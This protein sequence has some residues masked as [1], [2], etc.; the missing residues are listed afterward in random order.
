M[1]RKALK[2]LAGPFLAAHPSQADRVLPLL[3][4][5]LVDSTWHNLWTTAH[6]VACKL[7][8][9]LLLGLKQ[10]AAPTSLDAPGAT[11]ALSRTAAAALASQAT[12]SSEAATALQRLLLSR[13][14]CT[15][16]V[17][18]VA[19]AA[20]YGGCQGLALAILQQM[21]TGEWHCASGLEPVPLETTD[22]LPPAEWMERV[23]SRQADVEELRLSATLAALQAG[24]GEEL[25]RLGLQVS[26]P[27]A[28]T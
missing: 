12:K 24:P 11:A 28:H 15:A 16:A 18:L 3:L 23:G 22:G 19:C 13:Q 6:K 14:G 1:A 10:V 20:M 4:S 27:R 21:V 8:H 26:L 9:P 7:D 25:Q 2:T 17:L 5:S